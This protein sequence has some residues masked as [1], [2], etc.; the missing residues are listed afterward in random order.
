MTQMM[1]TV[2]FLWTTNPEIFNSDGRP[3]PRDEDPRLV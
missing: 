1:I 3:S 2:F